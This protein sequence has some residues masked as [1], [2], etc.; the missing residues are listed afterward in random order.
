[1]Q[2]RAEIALVLRLGE[3]TDQ[4]RSDRRSI[5]PGYPMPRAGKRDA[6]QFMPAL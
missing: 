1:V 3:R 6:T 4:E 5:E 2:K